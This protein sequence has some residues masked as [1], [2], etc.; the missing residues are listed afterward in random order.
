[1]FDR[2]DEILI[3]GDGDNL[4]ATFFEGVLKSLFD[5]LKEDDPQAVKEQSIVFLQKVL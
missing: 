2:L 5:V 4:L 3:L 1:L